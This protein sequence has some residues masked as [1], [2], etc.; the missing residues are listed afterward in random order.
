M[1]SSACKKKDDGGHYWQQRIRTFELLYPSVTHYYIV[2]YTHT[3]FGTKYEDNPK[4]EISFIEF[5]IF[6]I[7][8]L[9]PPRSTLFPYTTLFRSRDQ[10]LAGAALAMD[11]N[12]RAARRGLDDQRSEEHTSELQ[13]HVTFVCRLLLAK[14][15]MMVGIIGSS[16]FELLSCYIL[17][18]LIITLLSILIRRSGRSTRIIRNTKSPLSNSQYLKLICCDHRDLHSFP[19]RRS[20]DL[21]TSSLPVPL[22]PWMRIVERLGAAWMIRDRKSTRL[23]SSHMSHSYA[24]FCLQKKR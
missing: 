19:T 4:Y 11:E 22:S 17:V 16:G 1:P 3:S 23:N 6:K 9:R 8:L 7:D 14:K 12:R 15:K 2:E 10:L 21:A 13:S 18:S 20:S 5:P 24:V